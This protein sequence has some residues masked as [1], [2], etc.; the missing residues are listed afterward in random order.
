MLIIPAIDLLDGK[1]VR[2]KQGRY[3]EV[4][5]YDDDPPARARGWRGKVPRLH[6]VD[7]AGAKAGHAVQSDVVREIVA[8]FGGG[9]QIGGGVRTRQAFESYRALGADRVVLGSAALRDPA[10]VLELAVSH[11]DR[12]IVA[13]DA[14]DGMVATEGWTNVSA[15]TATEL[16]ARFVN[17]PLGGILYTD[18]ARDGMGSGPNAEMTAKLAASTSVPVI[19]SGGIGT[20]E[21]LRELAARG[22]HSAI[23]GRALYDESFTLEDAV[24][25]ASGD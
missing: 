23:V 24:A 1:C 20:L 11:P 16:V 7:L 19:A 22:I 17:A 9:V 25:A 18:I 13:V 6:V 21:H 2:L 10:L 5:V 4:T 14:K 15:T 3:D 8:A 12:V